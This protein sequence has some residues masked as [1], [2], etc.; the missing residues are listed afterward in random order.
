MTHPKI[1]SSPHILGGKPCIEGTRISVELVL[2]LLSSGM[3]AD[4]ILSEYPSLTKEGILAAISYAA[5]KVRGD[6]MIP[7]IRQGD[8]I[9]FDV[10]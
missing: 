4:E 6:K 8:H 2:N 3:K 1:I 9:T 5:G 10:A 7:F